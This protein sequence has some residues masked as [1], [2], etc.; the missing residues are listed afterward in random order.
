[1][2][3]RLLIGDHVFSTYT[4]AHIV[5]IL[6]A[7]GLG[8]WQL[9]RIG[10]SPLDALLSLLLLAVT[11]HVSAH[12]YQVFAHPDFYAFH[13]EK[14]LDF[15]DGGFALHGGLLG[16]GLVL[17]GL[18]GVTRR[19]PWQ[20]ADALAPAAALALC[21][22]RL[23]CWAHGCCGGLPAGDDFLLAGWSV[24]LIQ[25]VER[26]LHPT[27]LYAACGA[28]LLFV[29]LLSLRGRKR[30]EGQ[31]AGLLLMGFSTLR[32]AVG[33]LRVEYEHLPHPLAGLGL[34]LTSPQLMALAFF[35]LG[36]VI[37]IARAPY[38]ED[39]PHAPRVSG[40]GG[41]VSRTA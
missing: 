40:P 21:C 33:F 13:P 41:P 28:L 12:A 4:V 29:L 19:S 23:G 16:S 5:G 32:F 8:L 30:F 37:L 20:L 7:F 35:A 3:P 34:P 9:R 2:Y 10:Y 25:N 38:A 26:S 31:L 27:Q 39:S 6:L 36:L 1:V 18:A 15:W 22:F 17:L 14:R 11:A 24:K